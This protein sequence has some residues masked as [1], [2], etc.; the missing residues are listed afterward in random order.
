MLSIVNNKEET[1]KELYASYFLKLKDFACEYVIFDEDA[2]N[3]V[4]D[5]FVDIWEKEELI[6]TNLNLMPYLFTS[7]KNRCLNLLRHK[8]VVQKNADKIQEEYHI[9]L[10]MNLESLEAFDQHLFSEPDIEE[11]VT[12][13][14]NTL[15]EKCREIFIMNKIEGKKQKEIATELQISLSTIESQMSIAYTKLKKELKNYMPLY[16]FLLII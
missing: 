12:R 7:V 1:F 9:M 13:A 11:I 5:L 16:L 14:I 10:Q 8:T 6:S 15:P 4:Q 3:I 2:E